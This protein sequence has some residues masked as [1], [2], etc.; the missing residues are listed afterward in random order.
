MEQSA[1]LI[2]Y[3]CVSFLFLFVCLGEVKGGAPQPA[4]G[5]PLSF[6]RSAGRCSL[7]HPHGYI[8]GGFW[9]RRKFVGCFG[10]RGRESM[11]LVPA[12]M[13]AEDARPVCPIRRFRCPRF[14]T[15]QMP[16]QSDCLFL[17]ISKCTFFLR[18]I[19]IIII[20]CR[21]LAIMVWVDPRLTLCFKAVCFVISSYCSCPSAVS[22]GIFGPCADQ[23]SQLATMS[24]QRQ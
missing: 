15:N 2:G 23:P 17:Q 3:V 22:I 20:W 9:K 13:E 7:N 6:G 4:P 12:A 16:D 14:D 11:M 8:S 19:E 21:Q 18:R 24:V 5:A 10:E 1:Q